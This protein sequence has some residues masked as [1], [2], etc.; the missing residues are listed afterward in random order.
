MLE[1]VYMGVT[2]EARG[3][4]VGD[5]L[6]ARAA[7]ECARR[8]AAVLTLAVDSHNHPALDLYQRWAFVETARRRAWI[9]TRPE[10]E[11]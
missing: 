11:H 4:G 1:V 7:D 9:A 2:P 8:R 5:T 6:L 10:A 3:Q